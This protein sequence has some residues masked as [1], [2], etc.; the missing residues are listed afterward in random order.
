MQKLE[1][2]IETYL[3]KTPKCKAFF[4]YARGIEPGGVTRT[5]AYYP[6]YPIYIAKGEGCYA[7]DLDGNRRI[8]FLMNYSSMILGYAHPRIIS[9]VTERLKYG[10]SYSY[11]NELE[12][13][14]AEML[15]KR[16]PSVERIRFTNSGMEATMFAVRAA[17]AFTGKEKIA[18]FEGGYHGTTDLL[19]MSVKPPID[20]AGPASSPFTIPAA[21][22]IPRNIADNVVILPYNDP[23]ATELLIRKHKDVLGAVI[24]E[25]F[26]GSGQIPARK[27]F[28]ESLREVTQKYDIIL[29]F[30]E[31]QSFRLAPGGAQE[32][33]DVVPDMTT[34]GKIIGGG[35]PVGAFGGRKDVMKVFEPSTGGVRFDPITSGTRIYQGGTYT[36]NPITMAA[37]IATLQELTPETYARLEKLGNS[38]RNKL[39]RLFKSLNASMAVTGVGS[40]ANIHCTSEEI[41]DYRSGSE[42][43]QTELY[44]VFLSLMNEGILIAP[45]GMISLSTPITENEIDA[46]VSAM[47]TALS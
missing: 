45:R 20:K 16:I 21:E 33:Y 30:D 37:G 12:L 31:V 5:V 1:S 18:K 7:Y 25:P 15:C 32:Y 3:S 42:E 40:M 26:L 24:I 38:L 46:F 41:Y 47:E 8:D 19:Q 6:P 23:E 35:F 39:T 17:C 34:L 29:I 44:R 14:L 11:C 28:L 43:D 10:T 4:E 9:V 27:N 2:V 36:G 13:E 22:G